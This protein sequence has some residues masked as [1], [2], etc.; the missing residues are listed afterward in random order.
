MK[1]QNIKFIRGDT[2]NLKINLK[3]PQGSTIN[4]FLSK[5]DL[6]VRDTETFEPLIS[7]STDP[8]IGGITILEDGNLVVE[9]P[10]S[11]T[12]DAEWRLANYDLQITTREGY[13]KTLMQGKF[14]LSQDYTLTNDGGVL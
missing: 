12:R 5:F 6:Q 11:T 2:Y 13:V 8:S 14:V 4:V 7:R 1:K 9:F 10:P 3:F